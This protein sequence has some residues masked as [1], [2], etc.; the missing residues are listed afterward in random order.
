MAIEISPVVRIELLPSGIVQFLQDT[1][2][3]ILTSTRK[4]TELRRG[5]GG[6]TGVAPGLLWFSWE[7]S[8]KASVVFGIQ[9]L[10]QIV[11]PGGY[12]PII[13]TYTPLTNSE[14]GL[15]QQRLD[16]VYEY[17][18][19]YVFK[20]CCEDSG[21]SPIPYITQTYAQWDVI[22]LANELPEGTW[23]GVTDIP[24]QPD[25]SFSLYCQTT[26]AF[27]LGGHGTFL[28]ADWQN[29][30]DYSGVLAV[31]AVPFTANIGQWYAGIESTAVN[32]DVVIWNCLHYQVVDA[33]AFAGTDPATNVAAYT[34]LPKA[35]AN[36]G[37]ITEVDDI[38]FDF[39]NDWLQYRADKRGNTYRYSSLCDTSLTPLGY[40]AID[41]FQWGRDA[42]FSCQINESRFQYK[43]GVAAISDVSMSGRSIIR[44]ITTDPSATI[45]SISA[46]DGVMQDITVTG[47]S[48][49]QNVTLQSGGVFENSS[50]INTSSLDN[51]CICLGAT[52]SNKT[53]DSSAIVFGFETRLSQTFA[54][55]ISSRNLISN[56]PGMSNDFRDLDITGLTTLDISANTEIVGIYTLTSSNATES[57]NDFVYPSWPLDFPF[58]LKPAAGL[59]LTINF[60]PVASLT[61]DGQIVGVGMNIVLNGD[62][63]DYIIFEAA[64]ISGFKVVKQ[65][66]A[67]TYT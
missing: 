67:Q 44:N 15:Y 57:I 38:E 66:D 17:L 40:T 53:I 3:P 1:T 13:Q 37:Y 6:P 19:R 31:T 48:I 56:M 25:A 41:D 51:V 5:L 20:G 9:D 29:V 35:T 23:V 8:D 10:Q 4:T 21:P 46:V 27:S 30:G 22:R 47:S 54:E 52:Y 7:N 2:G 16:D 43:N 65:I 24:S 36:L 33:M 26:G 45:F 60:T 49:L 14:G 63:G 55:T 50:I 28:N 58:T 32:G 64:T 39:P 42:A 12:F 62:N 34:L 18:I 11:I 61:T 59:T